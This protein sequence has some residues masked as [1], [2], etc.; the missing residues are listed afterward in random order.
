MRARLGL[1]LSV[2]SLMLSACIADNGLTESD[3]QAAPPDKATLCK[4]K[5]GKT[6]FNEAKALLGSPAGQSG[7]MRDSDAV[8]AYSYS[9]ASLTL[10]FTDGVLS[11]PT[12]VGIAYPD[13]W[14]S[15]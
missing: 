7:S 6:T 5:P 8:L 4:L 15:K 9:G 13:C 2:A 3:V 11:M 14:S 12:V 1:F 10:Q